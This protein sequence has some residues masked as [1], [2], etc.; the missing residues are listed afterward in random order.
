MIDI[1]RPRFTLA[2]CRIAEV[3]YRGDMRSVRLMLALIAS[4]WAIGLALPGDTLARPVYIYMR[5][6]P[7]WAWVVLWSAVAAG[8]FWRLIDQA[9]RHLAT[10]AVDVAAV[11]V[12]SGVT[13]AM[14]LSRVWPFPAAI[15]PDIAC[16]VCS[17]WLAMRTWATWEQAREGAW[18]TPK[19]G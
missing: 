2:L 16:S 1:A 7:E 11:I 19:P 4:F 13:S 10:M 3:I 17:L 14:V 12:F 6:L 5:F 18:T 8:K 15:A 9:D